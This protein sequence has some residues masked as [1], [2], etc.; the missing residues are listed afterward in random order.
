M[1]T[2]PNTYARSSL[3]TNNTAGGQGPRLLKKLKVADLL[4]A[5]TRSPLRT[6]VLVRTTESAQAPGCQSAENQETIGTRTKEDI[7]VQNQELDGSDTAQNSKA[8]AL[9]GPMIK[10]QGESLQEEEG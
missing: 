7:L 6:E 2:S 5:G 3:G 8:A 4:T 10:V 1:P 9:F